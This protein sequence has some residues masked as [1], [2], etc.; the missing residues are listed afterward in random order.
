VGTR[1]SEDIIS[2]R[3][4]SEDP[5]RPFLTQVIK[6][7]NKESSNSPITSTKIEITTENEAPTKVSNHQKKC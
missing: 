1:Q 6:K 5:T 7:P 2:K 3:A 4:T